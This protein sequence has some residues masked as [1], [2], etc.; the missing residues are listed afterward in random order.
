[1]AVGP[2][3]GEVQVVLKN[4]SDFTKSFI[5][6]G[7]FKKYLGPEAGSVIKKTNEEITKKQKEVK[8]LLNSERFLRQNN[9]EIERLTEKLNMENAKVEQLKEGQEDEAEV[10]RKQQLIKNMEQDLKSK[11]KGV[12]ELKKI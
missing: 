9:E 3:G 5:S 8:D 7:Y 12:K 4:G 11:K 6:N 1:M 10:K 2:K